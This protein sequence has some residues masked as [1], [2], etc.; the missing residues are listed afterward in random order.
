MQDRQHFVN[1]NKLG[2]KITSYLILEY[3]HYY[4]T[5]LNFYFPK[6]I[7]Y[8]GLSEKLFRHNVGIL[9]DK[10]YVKK[11]NTEVKGDFVLTSS[12]K[13]RLDRMIASKK[14]VEQ[15][16]ENQFMANYPNKTGKKAAL[17]S[18]SKISFNDTT[19]VLQDILDGIENRK[20]WIKKAPSKEFIPSWPM[21]ATYLNGERWKDVLEP[22]TVV[23]GEENSIV[24]KP[25][26]PE[27]L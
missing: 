20:D 8:I 6:K 12:V 3:M 2:I 26:K 27:K 19:N 14:D 17:V 11:L 7:S 13:G 16:F 23:P 22:W 18:F 24:Y 25:Q 21:P 5:H 10:K 1:A 4:D 9:V 15:L